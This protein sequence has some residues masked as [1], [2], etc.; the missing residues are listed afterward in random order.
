MKY[1]KSR[2]GIERANIIV[3]HRVTREDYVWLAARAKSMGMTVQRF[4]GAC[5]DDGLNNDQ[6]AAEE[7]REAES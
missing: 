4:L 2:D 7:D 5:L 6:L 1:T 3:K